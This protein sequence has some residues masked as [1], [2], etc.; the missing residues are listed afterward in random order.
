MPQ[1]LDEVLEGAKDIKEDGK[2][3]KIKKELKSWK[4]K[5]SDSC[6]II[7]I[8]LPNKVLFVKVEFQRLPERSADE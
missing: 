5:F 2:V 4:L 8:E 1:R 6:K 3:L 7:I